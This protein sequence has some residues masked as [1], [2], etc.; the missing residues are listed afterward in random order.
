[1]TVYGFLFFAN[2]FILNTAQNSVKKGDYMLSKTKT[3]LLLISLVMIC[4]VLP[5]SAKT[6]IGVEKYS[7]SIAVELDGLPVRNALVIG[8]SNKS[9]SIYQTCDE[10]GEA[11]LK[12]DTRL[13]KIIAVTVGATGYYEIG[14]ETSVVIAV[15]PLLEE[16]VPEVSTR[17]VETFWS[18]Y[19]K[20]SEGDLY[21]RY[22]EQSNFSHFWLYGNIPLWVYDPND[23]NDW[24]HWALTDYLPE[25][26]GHKILVPRT[27]R[28]W[29]IVYYQRSIDNDLYLVSVK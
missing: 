22:D 13:T 6:N 1:M 29:Y 3:L 16:D 10:N 12:S 11:V 7:Y 19:C 25:Y 15:E 28:A 23:P 27:V 17:L 20:D 4:A 26:K 8:T 2:L 21:Y 14:K 9:E 5:A 24:G 18:Y